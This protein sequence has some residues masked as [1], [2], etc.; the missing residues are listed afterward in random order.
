[1]RLL[2]TGEHVVKGLDPAA[3]FRWPRAF[4]ANAHRT[5]H[6]FF[7]R[8]ALLDLDVD[9]P[10]LAKMI[11]VREQRPVFEIEVGERHITVILNHE[12][13]A[14][15]WIAKPEVIEIKRVRLVIEPIERDLDRVVQPRE[16]HRLAHQETAPDHRPAR[17][18]VH[19]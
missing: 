11:S 12:F 3:I 17:D 1:M 16:P 7:Q 14:L 2:D 10:A 15:E 13:V 18:H 8:P 5:E 9:L 6:T 19:A 4:T